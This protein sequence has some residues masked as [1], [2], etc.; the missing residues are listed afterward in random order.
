MTQPAFIPCSI[1]QLNPSQQ[2]RAAAA[3]IEHNPANRSPVERLLRVEPDLVLS[4]DHLA[5]LTT[6][7]WGAGGVKL[8]VAFLDTNDSTLQNRILSHMNAWSQYANVH[9]TLASAASADV[10]IA[11]VAGDGYWSYLGTDIRMIPRS[12]PTMNLD[13]FSLQT[14]ESEYARVV[15]HETGHTLGFPHEHLRRQIV[16][17]L[18]VNKTI[19][20]FEETQGWS[21]EE[22]RQQVLTALED[23]L[24]QETPSADVTSIMCYTLPPSITIDGKPIVGG[25]DIDPTDGAFAAKVYPLA[26]QPPGPPPSAGSKTFSFA[27][28]GKS[29]TFSGTV[30]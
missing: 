13:S 9:F 30:S 3:A 2:V 12:E 14:P 17:L 11:R 19:A 8:G 29:R 10:R 28:D 22:V 27:W 15:R 4:P 25:L 23:R 1:K 21:A 6:K 20:Y 24:L 7:Y 16:S 26:V 5:L 18:D